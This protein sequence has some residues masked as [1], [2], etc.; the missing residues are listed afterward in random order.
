MRLRRFEAASVPEA[1]EQIRAALGPDAIILSTLEERNGQV[2]VTAAREPA[3][4]TGFETPQAGGNGGFEIVDIIS[5][6]LDY[7]R[8]PPALF[9]TILAATKRKAGDGIAS[10]GSALASCLAWSEPAFA[11]SANPLMLVGMHGSG[12]TVAAAKIGLS[13]RLCDRPVHVVTLDGSKTGGL[14]QAEGLAQLLGAKVSSAESPEDLDRILN[15]PAPDNPLF[16]IDTPGQNPF[17]AADLAGLKIL[18]DTAEAE[19]L[20]IMA[21]GSDCFEAADAAEAFSRIGARRMI[22]TKV[23]IT[24]RLGGVVGAA[25]A[26]GVALS[27]ISESPLIAEGLI[28]LS[29]TDLAE[30]LL[31]ECGANTPNWPKTEVA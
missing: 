18:I 7:H 26:T 29:P 25:H 22:A 21:A 14:A 1:M 31:A 4:E 20:H 28:A 6:T 12:K 3:D 11:L 16:I 17:R 24:R 13:A 10:L 15:V 8:V 27:A 2:C 30:R 5:R 23:D 19:P 9:E